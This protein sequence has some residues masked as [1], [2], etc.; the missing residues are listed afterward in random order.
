MSKPTAVTRSR[1]IVILLV[2]SFVGAWW[3]W[4]SAQHAAARP[5][6]RHYAC[7]DVR[8]RE[9]GTLRGLRWLGKYIDVPR[10]RA[11][12][13]YDAYSVFWE[14]GRTAK[15][16]AV[17]AVAVRLAHRE[18]RVLY[19]MLMRPR[20]L[21]TT[22]DVLGA[23]G[24]LPDANS[25]GLKVRPLLGR[26]QS[27]LRRFHSIHAL[28]DGIG[29]H[30][31]NRLNEDD[32]FALLADSY[33]MDRANAAFPRRIPVPYGLANYLIAL[34]DRP[35]VTF[36]KDHSPYHNHF[37]DQAYWATHVAYSLEDYGNLRLRPS[38][39]GPIWTYMRTQFQPVVR[40]RGDF[41]L[42]AEMV[43]VFRGAGLGMKDSEVCAGTSFVLSHQH[44][45][46]SFADSDRSRDPYNAIHPTWVGV[47]ALRGR[48]FLT[49]TPFARRVRQIA[50]AVAR[51]KR[52][53]TRG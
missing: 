32:L 27:A 36:A 41:D 52:G 30:R 10:H 40:W 12:I 2:A 19:R 26:V 48:F 6:H 45:D 13:P 53:T 25:L 5:A 46:G 42:V 35:L 47:D 37:E 11:A 15:S 38:D 34:V 39:I 17:R 20:G 9:R 24:L 29:V 31:L 3:W 51:A 50:D 22:Q 8:A 16:R 23:V 43:D 4:G 21:R 49:R 18:A 1:L 28:Y 7:T 44:A 33:A 14:V